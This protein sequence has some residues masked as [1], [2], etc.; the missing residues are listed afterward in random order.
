[1]AAFMRMIISSLFLACLFISS[2]AQAQEGSL[3]MRPHIGVGFNSQQGTSLIFGLDIGMALDQNYRFG[4]TGYYSSGDKPELDRET[5][6]GFFGSYSQGITES[7]IVHARQE[8][9]YMD[10]RNP[11]DPEPTVG[12]KYETEYG[13]ASA[14]SAGIT[15]Y[16]TNNFA[17]SAGYRLV[18]GL[19]NSDLGDGR[20]GPTLGLLFG[21]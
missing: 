6:G 1:M 20:S 14:T 5:G 3:Y 7:L 17:L 4:I 13:V 11:L 15:F 12:R 2:L 9:V 8:I 18:I 21:F 19:T 16:I 10:V